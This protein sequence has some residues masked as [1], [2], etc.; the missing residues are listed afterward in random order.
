MSEPNTLARPA[1]RRALFWAF[2]VLAMQGFGGVLTIV[3]RD[4]VE[5]KRWMTL[6]QFVDDWAVAQTLPGA[7]VINLSLMIGDRYFGWTGAAVAVAGMLTAPLLVLLVV[8]VLFSTVAQTELAQ[9]ALRGMGAVA[10]G[11]IIA[12]GMKL[13]GTL[14][15][16]P[17]GLWV[18]TGLAA[19][20]FVAVALLRWPLVWVLLV[21]GGA[22][23]LWSYRLLGRA[24]GDAA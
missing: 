14:V 13:L 20:T 18:C 17:M 22:A 16:N 4:L 7:N 19:L 12:T 8:V 5:R 21:L 11:L 6:E 9:G 15:K 24:E 23:C 2:T 10:A 3:Q 1:S